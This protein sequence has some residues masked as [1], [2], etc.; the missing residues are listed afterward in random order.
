MT[1]A[2]LLLHQEDRLRLLFVGL[3]DNLPSPECR[4]LILNFEIKYE[5]LLL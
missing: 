2:T 5:L 4:V 3:A 1:P